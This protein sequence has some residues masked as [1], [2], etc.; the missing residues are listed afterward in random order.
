[1]HAKVYLVNQ[2]NFVRLATMKLCP[3]FFIYFLLRW[4]RSII[5]KSKSRSSKQII[6]KPKYRF[7]NTTHNNQNSSMSFSKNTIRWG[8]HHPTTATP[9]SINGGQEA[10]TSRRCI[11]NEYNKNSI[12]QKKK[13]GYCALNFARSEIFFNLRSSTADSSSFSIPSQ[14]ELSLRCPSCVSPVSKSS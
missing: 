4:F 6:L 7:S 3:I 11:Y 1:M 14:P 8:M 2:S 9:K 13:K 10:G 12:S 5:L